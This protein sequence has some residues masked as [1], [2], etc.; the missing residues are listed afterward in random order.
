MN[1]L[2]SI[3]MKKLIALATCIIFTNCATVKE[4]ED[5]N[6]SER[7]KRHAELF[8]KYPIKDT[9]SQWIG[10]TWVTLNTEPPTGFGTVDGEYIIVKLKDE[11][12]NVGGSTMYTKGEQFD[13]YDKWLDEINKRS[14]VVIASPNPTSSSVTLSFLSGVKFPVNFQFDVVFDN[15]KIYSHSSPNCIGSEVIP[16]SVLQKEGIYHVTYNVNGRKNSVSFWVKK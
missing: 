9:T 6:V 12:G 3:S 10:D 13:D 14:K 1:Y 16:A 8:S 15:S 5:E 2:K 11:D 7:E 4:K